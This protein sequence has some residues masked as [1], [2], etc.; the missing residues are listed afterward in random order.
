MNSALRTG[1]R[2]SLYLQGPLM[3]H[4]AELITFARVV[5]VAAGSDGQ[6]T[7]R[8]ALQTRDCLELR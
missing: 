3:P 6:A 8:I 1:R 4:R 7:L 2:V 5:A